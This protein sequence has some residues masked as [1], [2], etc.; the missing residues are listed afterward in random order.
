MTGWGALGPSHERRSGGAAIAVEVTPAAEPAEDGSRSWPGPLEI[1]LVLLACAVAGVVVG[2]V[3]ELLTPLPQFRVSGDRIL[4][5]GGDG[6]TDVAADGWFAVCA[7]VAGVVSAVVAFLRVREARISALAA[8][9]LGGLLASVVAWRV[10]VAVG[11]D[12][13]RAGAAG[14]SDGESFSGPLDLSALGVLVTGPLTS[15]ITYFALAAGL[16]PRRSRPSARPGPTYAG[17]HGSASSSPQPRDRYGDQG[18][19]S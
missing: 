18:T 12:S 4:T 19:W 9:S 5:D 1:G 13:V 17:D 14:L 8:L 16:D 15:V 2:V 10:G 11:P 6:E 7:G 3:W